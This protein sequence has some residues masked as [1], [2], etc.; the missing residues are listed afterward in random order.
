[1]N[2]LDKYLTKIEFD[3]YEDFYT[4]FSVKIPDNFNFAYDVLD[5]LAAEKGSD[6]ALV[7]CDE[8]GA[9]AT[10]TFAQMKT[11]SDKAATA[12]Q[13]A[14]I[15]KGDPVMLILK[16]R[17]EYWPII[18]A[19]HKLG[20]VTIPATHL[21]STKDIEYRCSVASIVAIICVDDPNVVKRVDEA[22]TKLKETESQ[23]NLRYKAFVRS[24]HNPIDFRPTGDNDW[25]D[26]SQCME[27]ASADFKRPAQVNTNS[28]IM[29]LYFT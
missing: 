10:F 20:A 27:N 18:L 1:M 15:G 24:V 17:W 19:L 12:L 3:S 23:P 8:L 7:R 6:R 26:F 4:N 13:A 22:E 28:D 14:G 25:V 16:R 9:E 11:L 5:V 21:L 2:L 29:L